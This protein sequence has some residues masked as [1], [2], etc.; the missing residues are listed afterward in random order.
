MTSWQD[1]Q[2]RGGSRA[3]LNAAAA[4]PTS[5]R[6]AREAERRA[7]EALQERL[8]HPS[9]VVDFDPAPAGPVFAPDQDFAVGDSQDIWAALTRDGARPGAADTAA[10]RRDAFG[11][12]PAAEGSPVSGELLDRVRDAV[13]RRQDTPAAGPSV[14][15]TTDP[16]ASRRARRAR[17]AETTRE[18]GLA[19]EPL[20]AP[21]GFA[22]PAA[23]LPA[24]YQE[25]QPEPRTGPVGYAERVAPQGF[26]EY[27]D[28]DGYY[29]EPYAPEP[30]IAIPALRPMELEPPLA[31]GANPVGLPSSFAE[32]A[33]TDALTF[34]SPVPVAPTG[35]FEERRGALADAPFHEP[36]GEW[37]DDAPEP[38]DPRGLETGPKPAQPRSPFLEPQPSA[39][40][41]PQLGP[42]SEVTDLAGFEALIRK[43]RQQPAGP[44]APRP[45]VA[46]ADDEEVQEGFTGLLSRS[47]QGS[48]GSANALILPNDPQPDLVSAVSG[49]GDIFVTG[50]MNLPRSLSTTGTTSEHDSRDIDRLFDVAQDEPSAGVAPVRASR[51]ISGDAQARVLVGARRG[52]GN[53]VPT[54]LAVVAGVMAL[55]VVGLLVVSWA[56]NLF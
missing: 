6:A 1:Q 54:V 38:W 33:G 19:A 50:S 21:Q 2:D 29:D 18:S 24:A 23:P 32:P 34:S 4:Q 37:E 17:E 49:T 14:E 43:A 47:V 16:G 35:S 40:H 3:P 15:P 7:A 31:S 41:N 56:S 28:D 44:S 22:E 48:H 20:G 10:F 26:Q 13:L 9:G 5:R 52:S 45:A 42:P 11:P 27:D 53:V 51:A 25:P 55:G 30:T 12:R 39:F 8:P 46:W 36:E